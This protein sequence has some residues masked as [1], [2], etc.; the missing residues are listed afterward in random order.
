MWTE[1]F[2]LKPT[3]RA[4]H[5]EAFDLLLSFSLACAARARDACRC[6]TQGHLVC[7]DAA[8]GVEQKLA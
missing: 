3:A 6:H 8:K 4:V 5:L 1:L 2:L 7:Q